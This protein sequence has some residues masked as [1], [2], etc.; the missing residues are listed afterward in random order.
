MVLAMINKKPL[1]G[2]N[3]WESGGGRQARGG[4]WK[5]WAISGQAPRRVPLHDPGRIAGEGRS[6]RLEVRRRRDVDDARRGPRGA[7]ARVPSALEPRAGPGPP[8]SFS[9]MTSD[10]SERQ[11]DLSKWR[12]A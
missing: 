6:S 11:G 1:G 12:R 2:T 3:L 5:F 10:R 4:F 7:G 9:A 8:G